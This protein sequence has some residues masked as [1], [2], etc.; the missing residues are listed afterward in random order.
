[1]STIKNIKVFSTNEHPCSYLPGREATT[2]FV[3][4]NIEV[5]EQIYSQLNNLGFRRSGKHLYLPHCNN[6]QD[7]IATRVIVQEFQP[8]RRH[9]RVIKANSDIKIKTIDCIDNARFYDLYQRY[10]SARHPEGDMHPPSREQYMQF[11]GNTSNFST[12]LTMWVNGELL[13][14]TVLDQL[15]EG[16]SAIYTFFDPTQDK[17][18]L[19]VFS[20]L[21][22]IDLARQADFDYVYLGYWIRECQK[23]AY[24]IEYKP[25]E[26]LINGRWQRLL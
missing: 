6:C 14:V 7:C 21:T 24:K 12:Y 17:R 19:G 10:I 9:R 4:P 5:T 20:I 13:S 22:A 23:M 26:L 18:S 1:M 16:Y 15:P 2:L 11:I 8:G 3:D 25:I